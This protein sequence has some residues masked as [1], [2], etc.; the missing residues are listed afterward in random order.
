MQFHGNFEAVRERARHLR[1]VTQKLRRAPIV[2]VL[3]PRQVGKTT[4]ALEIAERFK[5]P[6]H[7]FDLERPPDLARLADPWL[8]LEPL[9]GLV[10]LDEVQR[11]PEIFPVLRVLADRSKGVRFLVLGSAS[12][13]LLQQSSETLAGRLLFHELTGFTFE[14]IQPRELRPLWVRGGFPGSF[15]ARTEAA[16][17]EWRDAFIRTFLERDLP[18]LGLV[19]P[20]NTLGRLWTMLAHVHGQQLS[21][22]ELG[23]SLGV[24][25]R[26]VRHSTEALVQTFMVRLLAPWHENLS[27]RQVKSPKLYLRDSG[28]LHALLNLRDETALTGHPVAGASWEGLCLESLL[29]HLGASDRECFFWATHQG[30]E[31]DA[32]IIRGKIRRGFEFKLSS[33]PTLSKSMKIALTDLKLDSLDVLYPGEDTF[34][35]APRV[36]AVPLRRLTSDI[37]PL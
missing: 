31:L 21:W 22:S 14:E 9:R 23:R 35:L 32:L 11:Q 6:V 16:S 37:R 5:G 34:P 27:K 8:A 20:P 4:L 19:F 29:R 36:R 33:A 15:L 13:Q 24:A 25:D 26:T 30:A 7:R 18:Q 17:F 10:I 2:A 28:L 12:P 3:G 1:E